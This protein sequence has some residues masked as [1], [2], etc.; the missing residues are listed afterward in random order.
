MKSPLFSFSIIGCLPATMLIILF[1]SLKKNKL[2]NK[3]VLALK[4]PNRKIV[5]GKESEL[6]SAPSAMVINAIKVLSKIP[7]DINLLSPS[8]LEPILK[9]RKNNKNPLQLQEVIIALSVCSVTNPVV[10]KALSCLDKLR[11]CEAH[12]SFIV[13]NGDKKV[14]K[15]LGIRLTC[16]DK[17]QSD[18]L[19]DD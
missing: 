12:A 11:D 15:N 16:E 1:S 9:Q 13:S 19:Y 6:L 2:S 7:D 14:L 8:V 4:L 18:N 17:F 5:T 3:N 10:E